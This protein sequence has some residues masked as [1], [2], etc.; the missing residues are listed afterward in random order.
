MFSCG[1]LIAAF[2][3]ML[4]KFIVSR[5]TTATCAGCIQCGLG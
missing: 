3:E 1:P 2:L 4:T 5:T